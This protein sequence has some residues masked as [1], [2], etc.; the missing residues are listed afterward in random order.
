MTD[1]DKGMKLNHYILA[2]I[3][4]TPGSGIRIN[5]EIRFKSQSTFGWD[6]QRSAGQVHLALVEVCPN[7][8]AHWLPNTPT[9]WRRR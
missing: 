1:A 8:S 6:N 5:P 4:E 9:S 2:V 7:L 3:Q